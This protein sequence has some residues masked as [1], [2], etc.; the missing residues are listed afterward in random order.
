[1]PQLDTLM[2]APGV[3]DILPNRLMLGSQLI[4]ATELG[5]VFF[6]CWLDVL[7]DVCVIP[8]KTWNISVKGF[9]KG[10]LNATHSL[11]TETQA[12]TRALP[13]P[14]A[15]LTHRTEI[16]VEGLARRTWGLC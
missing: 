2:K 13:L 12:T 5:N 16:M 6:K 1:M 11:S 14:Q 4:A 10:V 3:R 7:F 15:L 9:S 8:N